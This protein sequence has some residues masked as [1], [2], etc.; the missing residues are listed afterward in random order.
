MTIFIRPFSILQNYFDGSRIEVKCPSET[1][2]SQLCEIIDIRWGRT[3][4]PD[5]WNS[6][7]KR[8]AEKVVVMIGAKD[9]GMEEDPVLLDG[10]EVLLLLPFAGG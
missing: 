9:L 10:Q 5:L 4:P 1:T 7:S 2:F 3:L 6:K 8:F